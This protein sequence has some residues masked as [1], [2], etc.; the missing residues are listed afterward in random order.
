MSDIGN[1][2]TGRSDVVMS[3]AAA[4]PMRVGPLA[5]TRTCAG[6]RRR[7]SVHGRPRRQ[8]RQCYAAGDQAGHLARVFA[9]G[10]RVRTRLARS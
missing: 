10:C 8:H 1:G 6:D 7:C 2:R 9:F 3:A 5:S 4:N